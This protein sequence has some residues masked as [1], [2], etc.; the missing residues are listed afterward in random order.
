MNFGEIISSLIDVYKSIDVRIVAFFHDGLWKTPFLI[1]R[2]RRKSVDEVKKEHSNLLSK[3]GKIDN[4]SIK[5]RL[6]AF[7]T[8]KWDD[9][10]NSWAKNSIL[11]E[12]DFG[13]NF[14]NSSSLPNFDLASPSYYIYDHLNLFWDSFHADSGRADSKLSMF[15]N[16]NKEA[17]KNKFKNIFEYIA[18]AFQ[19]DE[20]K[21]NSGNTFMLIIAPI[22]FKVEDSKIIFNSDTISLSGKNFPMG[23]LNI[24][25][26]LYKPRRGSYN[27]GWKD[28][29]SLQHK[30][31]GDYKE[32]KEFDVDSKISSITVNDGFRITAYRNDG[33][34]VYEKSNSDVG[35]YWPSKSIKTNPIVP[36]FSNFVTSEDLIKIIFQSENKKGKQSSVNFEK[37]VSWLLGLL[38]FNPIWLG[39]DYQVSGNGPEKVSIDILGHVD[40]NTILLVNPTMGVPDVSTFAREKRYRENILSK[41]TTSE[42]EVISIIVTNASVQ[43]LKDKAEQNEVILIGKEEIELILQYLERGD[44]DQARKFILRDN[45]KSYF[46]SETFLSKL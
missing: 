34:I 35:K 4:D 8:S 15:K 16:F 22:F 37:G 19:V 39:D 9:F 31:E 23:S 21:I 25:I 29:I 3:I 33:L 1:I 28:R 20:Q 17:G 18:V 10:K 44:V 43:S 6:Y 40:T 24:V 36:V 27:G 46:K 13:V 41:L 7:P 14:L 42:I 12:E 5:I 11:L 26:D 2:F 45:F 38:G 30:L 32:P